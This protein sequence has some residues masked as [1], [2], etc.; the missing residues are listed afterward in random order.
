MTGSQSECEHDTPEGRCPQ[1]AAVSGREGEGSSCLAWF[2][3]LHPANSSRVHPARFGVTFPGIAQA[4][5][6]AWPHVSDLIRLFAGL[7]LG[8]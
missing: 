7:C 1:N 6:P 5:C 8:Q 2:A 3:L 4:G